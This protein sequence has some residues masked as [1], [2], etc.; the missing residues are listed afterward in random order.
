[1]GKSGRH[2]LT[3]SAAVPGRMLHWNR[4]LDAQ[5]WLDAVILSTSGIIEL[6]PAASARRMLR[7]RTGTGCPLTSTENPLDDNSCSISS[8]VTV[9]RSV[10]VEEEKEEEEEEEGEG[11]IAAA[12]ADA[13]PDADSA[14]CSDNSCP[15]ATHTRD[16]QRSK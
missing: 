1:M 6:A 14:G 4:L 8:A 12:V 7:S 2:R 9:F 15:A 10:E 3:V 5:V 11:A 16:N 13:P